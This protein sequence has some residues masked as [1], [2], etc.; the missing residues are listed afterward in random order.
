M[1]VKLLYK[2]LAAFNG[3]ERAFDSVDCMAYREK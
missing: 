3:I 2:V 1:K